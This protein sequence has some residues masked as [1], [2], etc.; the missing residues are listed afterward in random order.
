MSW[1]VIITLVMQFLEALGVFDWIKQ[2]IHDWLNRGAAH[3]PPSGLTLASS[4][5][6]VSNAIR[7]LFDAAVDHAGPLE[8]PLLRF[9]YRIV[10]R[11]GD[12]LYAHL[13]GDKAGQPVT[14]ADVSPLSLP[15]SQHL[16]NY[17]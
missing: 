11:R 17:R 10:K 8:R 1:T 13:C 4:A 6:D 2:R 7:D 9:I 14:K 12:V 3:L 15:E 16:E 5:A